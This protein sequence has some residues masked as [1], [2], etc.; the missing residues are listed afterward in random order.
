MEGFDRQIDIT[1]CYYIENHKKEEKNNNGRTDS[2]SAPLC[3]PSLELIEVEDAV[4][5]SFA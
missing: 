1:G 5:S 2:D 4:P 3:S